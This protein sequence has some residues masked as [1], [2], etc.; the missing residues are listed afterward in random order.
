[1]KLL[2][3]SFLF[4]PMGIFLH[5]FNLMF[6][7]IYGEHS[8]TN[9]RRFFKLEYALKTFYFTPQTLEVSQ[10]TML[11]NNV[12]MQNFNL[13]SSIEKNIPVGNKK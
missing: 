10:Q 3:C 2:Y 8:G 7:K 5:Y 12:K 9:W 11:T 13:L 1:M 4:S 6:W